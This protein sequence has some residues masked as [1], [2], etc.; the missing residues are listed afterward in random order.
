MTA[1]CTLAD[2]LSLLPTIGT[3]KDAVAAVEADPDATPPVKAVA[4]VTATQPSLTQATALLAAVCAEVDMHLRGR[5]YP[6]PPTD[7]VML[8][9]VKTIAMNGT[10]AKIAKAKWPADSGAGGDAGV[11]RALRDD[12]AAGLKFIDDGG[13]GTASTGG[14]EQGDVTD[15]F[16]HTLTTDD[17]G[18][19]VR[20]ARQAP[21]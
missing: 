8:A 15:G 21:F 3:L 20:T 9:S 17:N 13:L 18:Y 12:Y 2:A 11:T 1:Y 4:A 7:A 6:V 10:A 16:D 14:T 5:D 19:G